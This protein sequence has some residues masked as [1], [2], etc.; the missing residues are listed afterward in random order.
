MMSKLL[1]WCVTTLT[2]REIAESRV[3]VKSTCGGE[4]V[5]DHEP[6]PPKSKWVISI[7]GKLA[8]GHRDN[9]PSSWAKLCIYRFPRYLKNGEDKAWVPQIVSLGPYHH[10]GEHLHHME[11]HKWRCLHRILE[12]SGQEIGLYLDSI[13]E[14]EQEARACYEGGISMSS[15]EFVE[16]MVLDGCFVIEML[17]GSAEGFKNLGYPPSDPIFSEQRGSILQI[18]Q[19]MIMLENQIPIFILN[20]LLHLL[21]SNPNWKGYVPNLTIWFFFPLMPTFIPLLTLSINREEGESNKFKFNPLDDHCL[22][23]FRNCLVRSGPM[24]HMTGSWSFDHKRFTRCLTELQE[25]GIKIRQG[26]ARLGD[27][28]FKDGILEIPSLE[29]HKWTRS[30]FL[31][32]IAFEQS[33]FD[34]SN[35]ITSYV[36]FM[37]HLINSPEDVRY[38]RNH[39]II[40]HYLE[41]DAQVAEF[42]IWLCQELSLD[43]R[44]NCLQDVSYDLEKYYRGANYLDAIDSIVVHSTSRAFGPAFHTPDICIRFLPVQSWSMLRAF[45]IRKVAFLTGKWNAWVDILKNKYFDNPWTIISLI[46]AFV[47]LVLT[48]IQTFY[49]VYAYYKPRS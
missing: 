49:A 28:K 12:R 39:G 8:Q 40:Y 45:L 35:Y 27:I 14:V 48:F 36:I 33:H 3:P 37:H 23:V 4:I 21:P 10:G 43:V 1:R 38:L 9:V 16:M 31:N 7:E 5:P 32:L 41:S 24:R 11:Q 20:R 6:T 44:D 29:I 26:Y 47:L 2:L 46:A 18:R 34:C 30:L 13:K 15:D 17:Q 42:F 19:D 25:A 22:E